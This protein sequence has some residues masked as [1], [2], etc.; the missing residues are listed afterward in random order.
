MLHTIL[1]RMNKTK[2]GFHAFRRF[3]VTHLRKNMVPED[4]I[5]FWIGHAPK[6]V[7]DEYS[8]VKN[9]VDFRREAAD[10]VGLG[11]DLGQMDSSQMVTSV[12]NF[13]DPMALQT[14]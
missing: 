5:K 12:H 8:K 1:S 2:L 13:S 10:K 6:T 4:L 3:R 11:F 7:T 14:V 9:D